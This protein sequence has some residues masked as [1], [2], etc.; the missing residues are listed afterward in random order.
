MAILRLAPNGSRALPA[1]EGQHKLLQVGAL[2][3]AIAL[4]HAEGHVLLFGTLIRTPET[5]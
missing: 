2:I 1:E 3:R 5:A 4:G